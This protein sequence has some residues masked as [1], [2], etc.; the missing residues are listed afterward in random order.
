MAPEDMRGDRERDQRDRRAQGRTQETPEGPEGTRGIQKTPGGPEGKH[1]GVVAGRKASG[2]QH[3]QLM[4][5]NSRPLQILNG[6]AAS[7]LFFVSDPR[8][9]L[10]LLARVQ[11]S[12][13]AR[14]PKTKC[15]KKIAPPSVWGGSIF[16]LK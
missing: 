5:A 8:A 4:L 13:F 1:G 9:A 2:I 10:G 12:L 7:F 16:S 11:P 6:K 14:P 15:G 3:S